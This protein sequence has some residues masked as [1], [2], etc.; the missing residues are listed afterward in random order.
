MHVARSVIIVMNTDNY[1][2]IIRRRPVCDEM[3]MH[4]FVYIC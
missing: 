2:I 4:A 3:Q 1:N